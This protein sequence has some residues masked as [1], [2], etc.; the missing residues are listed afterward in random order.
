MKQILLRWQSTIRLCV[1]WAN[2][3]LVHHSYDVNA[4]TES[5]SEL[6]LTNRHDEKGIK[7]RSRLA[8]VLRSKTAQT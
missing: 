7:K 6:A 1:L 3:G 4:A 5:P 8:E 2:E